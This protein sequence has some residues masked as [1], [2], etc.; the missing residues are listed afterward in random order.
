MTSSPGSSS[1]SIAAIISSV[2]PLTTVACVSGSTTHS[3]WKRAVFAAIASRSGFEPNVIAYWLWS[4]FT[5]SV[6]AA[7]SSGGQA[8]SGNPWARLTAPAAT[9]SRFISRMTDSVNDSALRLIWSMRGSVGSAAVKLDV[10]FIVPG[11]DRPAVLLRAADGGLPATQ[12]DG[13]ESEA[14][15]IPV[16]DFLRASWGLT[17]PVLETHPKWRGVAEG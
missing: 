12:L 7:F 15:V 3:G 11:V 5:A 6:T 16:T 4:A 8:K 9:A 2:A 10:W 17:A 14:A 1:P 13:D